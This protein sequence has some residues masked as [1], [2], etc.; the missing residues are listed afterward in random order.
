MRWMLAQP[1]LLM[2]QFRDRIRR[3]LFE[4]FLEKLCQCTFLDGVK[5]IHRSLKFK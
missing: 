4:I 2:Q 5:I 3:A 1:R